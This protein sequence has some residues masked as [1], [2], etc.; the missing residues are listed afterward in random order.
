MSFRMQQMVR[1]KGSSR[2]P[3]H[4]IGVYDLADMFNCGIMTA[5]A[6]AAEG[7][8]RGFEVE[9]MGY[10]EVRPERKCIR[11]GIVIGDVRCSVYCADCREENRIM[12]KTRPEFNKPKP[13]QPKPKRVKGEVPYSQKSPLAKMAWD[14]RQKGMSY[15]QYMTYLNARWFT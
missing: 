2:F 14:A 9:D 10:M 7:S 15:G 6:G 13:P 4:I 3:R 8:L 5:K 12:G 11:C 1:I